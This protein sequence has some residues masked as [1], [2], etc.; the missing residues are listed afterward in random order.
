M[1]H[2]HAGVGTR[3]GDELTRQV[4][5][6]LPPG[7]VSDAL[8]SLDIG[9][10]LGKSP[11]NRLKWLREALAHAASGRLRATD[12]YEIASHS[13]FLAG[14]PDDVD[15]QLRSLILANLQGFSP[16]QQRVMQNLAFSE[17]AAV[18]EGGDGGAAGCAVAQAAA[19]AEGRGDLQQFLEE[20]GLARY[21]PNFAL[22]G[23][24]TVE[25]VRALSREELRSECGVLPG[26]VRLLQQRLEGRPLQLNQAAS[27]LP[28]APVTAAEASAP[29]RQPM[30]S[31]SAGFQQVAV[32]SQPEQP[33]IPV[34]IEQGEPFQE[35]AG[36]D[37]SGR[38]PAD[39]GAVAAAAAAAASAR[40]FRAQA[41]LQAKHARE[42]SPAIASPA[43]LVPPA[44]S[45]A[46][47]D[48][49][50]A[51]AAAT[52]NAAAAAC[53]AAAASAAAAAAA[54]A[55]TAP[56]PAAPAE[57]R[58]GKAD[59]APESADAASSSGQ[60]RARCSYVPGR[61]P[62][63]SRSRGRGSATASQRSTERA[64]RVAPNESKCASGSGR[65]GSRGGAPRSRSRSRGARAKRKGRGR[66]SSSA[67]PRPPGGQACEK[68]AGGAS[69]KGFN[70]REPDGDAL[71]TEQLLAAKRLES[72]MAAGGGV[73]GIQDNALRAAQIKAA[74]RLAY[75]PCS[76]A[77]MRDGDWLC[78][79]C[80][81]HNYKSK[82]K[83]FRCFVG[84][85]PL[86]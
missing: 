68:T 78:T 54:A 75:V 28:R 8:P 13:K 9:H 27:L 76:S 25:A 15:R 7:A 4:A 66:S 42:A 50:A 10:V 46:A 23:L 47:P 11:E 79:T 84:M 86:R 52:A 21:A 38:L 5:G 12:L 48:T 74:Q 64:D 29:S 72:A 80:N 6:Y 60:G 16:E 30:Q 62:V 73:A 35:I 3:S 33:A 39:P 14:A 57:T 43:V 70:S 67:S 36:R 59:A 82:Q 41:Q 65:Q 22:R 55:V 31:H 77:P 20:I 63:R 71:R 85:R 56:V 40:E 45:S 69:S 37:S 49:A 2:G 83:C 26:H 51:T 81:A 53:A 44:Q 17:D 32:H 24:A 1:Q 61:S 18:A 58:Q 19:L 34:P